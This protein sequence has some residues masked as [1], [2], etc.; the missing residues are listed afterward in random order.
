MRLA[1]GGPC[2]QSPRR[3]G[4]SLLEV[5]AALAILLL[6]LGALYH[7][8]NLGGN[9][10][11]RAHQR[12]RAAQLAQTKLAEV[13]AGVVPLGSADGTFDE[14]D[15]YSWSVQAEQ[16]STAGLWSVTVTVTRQNADK[17]RIEVSLS[18]M[19][20]DPSTVGSTQDVPGG[21]STSNNQSGNQSGTSSTGN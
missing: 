7:L 20:L 18:Q 8:I 16:S 17:S 14:D 5:I 1:F 2:A 6:S 15:K 13:A 12:S 9:L 21:S 4:L 11:Y 10:A 3:P 19:V